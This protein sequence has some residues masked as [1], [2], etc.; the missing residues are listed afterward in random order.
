MAHNNSALLAISKKPNLTKFGKTFAVNDYY[1]GSDDF[2]FPLGHIQMLGKSD[3]VMYKED[4]P[5]IAPGFAL[6]LMANHALDF[7]M[8]SEDLPD[9]ENRVTLTKDGFL[10]LQSDLCSEFA[11]FGFESRA[12]EAS[13][14]CGDRKTIDALRIA[15]TRPR[16]S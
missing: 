12:T 9:P 15:D 5:A 2:E 13:T 11:V 3:P 4:A 14:G 7:W 1:F 10:A 8:T 16:S 6:E